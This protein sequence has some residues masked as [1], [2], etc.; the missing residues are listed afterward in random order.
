MQVDD[1]GDTEDRG[2]LD[3]ASESASPHLTAGASAKKGAPSMDSTEHPT[4]KNDSP[5]E[6][7]SSGQRAAGKNAILHHLRK[8]LFGTRLRAIVTGIITLI[9][10]PAIAAIIATQVPQLWSTSPDQP[11][12]VIYWEPWN[13]NADKMILN[14]VHV[15]HTVSGNCW[16][17]SIVTDRPDAYRC[18]TQHA[19]LDPCIAYPFLPTSELTEVACPYPDPDSITIIRLTRP[20]P[21]I[22]GRKI[23]LHTNYWFITLADGTRCHAGGGTLEFIGNIVGAY[24]YCPG[25]GFPVYG[26]PDNSGRTWTILEQRPGVSGLE[27]VPIAKAYS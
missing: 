6:S 14:N 4:D 19:I 26:Y 3:Q 12:Q 25:V 10:A 16:E 2:A 24:Y 23:P 18:A 8:W 27:P 9:G 7:N 22:S 20:L 13:T 21:H 17:S 1:Q 5:K 15:D 11:T